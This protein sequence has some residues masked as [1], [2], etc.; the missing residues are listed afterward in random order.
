MNATKLPTHLNRKLLSPSL[1][2]VAPGVAAQPV[3]KR[4]K[5]R[6]GLL[7]NELEY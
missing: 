4:D 7:L 5:S 2:C 3:T 6:G 1:G